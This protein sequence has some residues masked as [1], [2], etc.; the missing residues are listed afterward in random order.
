[1]RAFFKEEVMNILCFG[2]ILWDVY[3]DKAV[4]GGA[5]LNFAGHFAKNG[6]EAY[7]ISAVGDD[8]L[9]HEA[10][11]VTENLSV[12]TK[13]ISVISKQTGK[14]L[15]TLNEKGIPSYNLLNN[16]AYDF[17]GG[18]VEDEID[19][20]YFGTLAL[21]NEHNRDSLS[22]LL[23]NNNFKEIFCDVNIRAP[24]YSEESVTLCANTASVIKISDEELPIVSKILLGEELDYKAAAF[25]FA[26]KFQNLNTVIITL[27]PKGAYV[28]DAKNKKEYEMAAPKTDVLSTVGAGDSFSAAFMYK[29]MSG[30]NLENC[31]E[32]AIKISAFV[33]SKLEAIPD[34]PQNF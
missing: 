12:K 9:G 11:N 15:V 33:V 28:F 6:G 14:C 16:V 5:A 10:V 8:E 19:A 24:F 3:P 4:I 21:R 1:M 34:Y 32:T 31:L 22:K 13:Y 20:I 2:E 18:E 17:I 27:G 23:K 29:Y 30:E 25:K 26:E 7:M